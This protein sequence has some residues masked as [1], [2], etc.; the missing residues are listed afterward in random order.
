V[1]PETPL[2]VCVWKKSL[3]TRLGIIGAGEL[4]GDEDHSFVSEHSR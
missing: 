3:M 1:I 4:A 2:T